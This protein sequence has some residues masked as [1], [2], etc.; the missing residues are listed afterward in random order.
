[1]I[2]IDKFAYISALKG[3]KPELKILFGMTALI[4]CICSQNFISFGI[5][6]ATMFLVTVV[7]A[8]I[9]M[10]Y[11][12]KLLLLPLGFL[13]LSVLGIMVNVSK[14]IHEA[15]W[16]TNV[17]GFY[18]FITA[19][20]MKLA[21]LLVFKSLAG[22]SCL[23][24]IILTTPIRDLIIFLKYLKC[25]E[26][27]I[28]LITLIYRFIFLLMEISITKIKSQQCRHGYEKARGFTK[29]FGMLWASV[30]VQSFL[31]GEWIHKAML[32]RGHEGN[33]KFIKKKFEI[34]IKELALISCFMLVVILPN[35]FL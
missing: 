7:R 28:T 12:V 35:W 3:T 11:Y 27:L 30:F 34:S 29:T 31:C 10:D 24:F 4:T 26:T 20:G 8:K 21:A 9:P 14:E 5:V 23:Y 33:I 22:V 6:F 16:I 1:M 32:V 17:S 19:S 15:L 2:Y 13:V 25:P 18:V